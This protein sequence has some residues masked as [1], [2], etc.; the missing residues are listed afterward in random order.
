M[1]LHCSCLRE[2]RTTERV[3]RL[4]ATRTCKQGKAGVP[5]APGTCVPVQ[6]SRKRT[7]RLLPAQM[8]AEAGVPEAAF[9]GVPVFQ[10]A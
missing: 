1:P 5:E 7:L 4:A 8:H 10:A 2:A 9:T 3:S 6:N